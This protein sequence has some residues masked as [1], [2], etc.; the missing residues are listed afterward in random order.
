MMRH[1]NHWVH[2]HEQN[3]ELWS[4]IRGYPYHIDGVG[5]VPVRGGAFGS[6][7]AFA[8]YAAAYPLGRGFRLG[9]VNDER[10]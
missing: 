10:W 1:G 4:I 2:T 8:A 6:E 5:L 9:S 7:V 3:V